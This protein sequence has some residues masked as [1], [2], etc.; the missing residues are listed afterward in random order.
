MNISN[1][2]AM[3]ARKFPHHEGI[4]TPQERISYAEWNQAVNR[5]PEI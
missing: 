5:K 4:V 3:Q 1:L 2:L